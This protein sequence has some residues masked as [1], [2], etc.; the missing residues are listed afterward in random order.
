MSGSEEVSFM[1]TARMQRA[2]QRV[3]DAKIKGAE[4][5]RV[6]Q[7]T[8]AS[9]DSP[10]PPPMPLSHVQLLSSLFRP[11]ANRETDGCGG[12][13]HELTEGSEVA[14]AAPVVKKKVRRLHLHLP[15]PPLPDTPGR[16]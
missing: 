14:V 16:A 12:W 7:N 6:Y 1:V 3:L 15:L 10:P 5:L 13:V 9:F 8:A 4:P 2:V 11:I